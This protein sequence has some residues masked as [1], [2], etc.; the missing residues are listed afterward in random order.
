MLWPVGFAMTAHNSPARRILVVDDESL[1]A[2]AVRMLLEYDGHA[3]ETASNGEEALTL[4]E[5]AK[6][7]VVITDYE[8]PGMKGD[9]LALTIKARAPNQPVVMITA[10]AEKL[11]S[12]GNPLTG[13]DCVISKPFKLEDL[14][15]A[16]AKV[17]A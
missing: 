1:V 9:Q 8:M 3:V 15:A 10:Y 14:R 5:K 17:L 6:F 16:I 12:S 11:A 13:I 7:D 2:D 4:F